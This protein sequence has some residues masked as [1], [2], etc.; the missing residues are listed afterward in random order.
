MINIFKS[1]KFKLLY[2]CLTLNVFL[3]CSDSYEKLVI[4]PESA[5]KAFLRIDTKNCIQCGAC[6]KSC[7]YGAISEHIIDDQY[8]YII[9]PEK[10]KRCGICIR[11]CPFG[12]ID[13]KR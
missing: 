11:N 12:A 7:P 4:N 6:F 8:I 2:I 3:S 9:D 5:Q 13:W 10:C 1:S